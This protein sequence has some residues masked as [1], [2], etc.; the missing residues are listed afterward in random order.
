MTEKS[1]DT[2]HKKTCDACKEFVPVK[3]PHKLCVLCRSCTKDKPCSLNRDWSDKS[4]LKFLS[5]KAEKGA[6]KAKAISKMIEMGKKT[7]KM[8]S[9][10]LGNQVEK[11]PDGKS[12]SKGVSENPKKVVSQGQSSSLG[13]KGSQSPQR[14]ETYDVSPG[15]ETHD[16]SPVFET[17]NV[18]VGLETYDVSSKELDP[19]NVQTFRPVASLIKTQAA[20][21]SHSPILPQALVVQNPVLMTPGVPA[22]PTGFL[23]ME[24]ESSGGG[25]PTFF[26]DPRALLAQLSLVQTPSGLL[27]D[28]LPPSR[29][30]RPKS[31][32]GA[33]LVPNILGRRFSLS[34]LVR[35]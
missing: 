10:V 2:R 15:L 27:P 6:K 3:D 7:K 13:K 19:K 29:L 25:V 31:S 21:S 22:K 11:L 17:Q 9:K 34:L 28:G 1:P 5:H 18:P 4:W 20:Q 16:V 30:N 12:V 8:S 24:G 14:L 23:V 33:Y 35:T 26:P 32:D